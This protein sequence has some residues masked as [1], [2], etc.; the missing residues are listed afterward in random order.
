MLVDLVRIETRDGVR[1]EGMLQVP[2]PATPRALAVDGCCL[3]HGTGSNFYGS[4]LFDELGERLLG[5]GAAVLRINTRGHDLMSNAATRKG[6]RRLGAAY[7]CVDDCRHDL[8]GW[9]DW[10]AER[11][12]PRIL[13]IGHSLG[14][15]KCLHFQTSESDEKI[16]GIAAISP[17]R[18]GYQWF[19]EG[20]GRELFLA[21]YRRA[22]EWAA[23]GQP[24]ALMEV[25]FPM[26]F[27]VSAAG[28]LE[29]YGPEERYD[30]L[31]RVRSLRCPHLF[32]YGEKETADNPVFRGL[33]EALAA[34][35][36]RNGRRTIATIP[37]ADHFYTG[38]R[39]DLNANI[40]NW[41]RTN[42]RP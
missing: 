13:L 8:S 40:E 10:L 30:F 39:G 15:V 29:K 26:P 23:S 2:E 27:V 19:C 32:A 28:Y 11:V 42:W 1:L 24:E 33:P 35:P 9:V 31:P 5:L 3:V 38:V 37:G 20:S 12:G 7:E 36:D 6:G 41:L 14:A 4:T 34:V 21:T 22:E 17:P 18:L 16:V 25:R